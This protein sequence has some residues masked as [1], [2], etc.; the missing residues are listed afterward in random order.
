MERINHAAVARESP[1]R[2]VFDRLRTTGRFAVL[3]VILAIPGHDPSCHQHSHSCVTTT[4]ETTTNDAPWLDPNSVETGETVQ[5]IGRGIRITREGEPDMY[6]LIER[7]N[8]V[9]ELS[10]NGNTYRIRD[11]MNVNVGAAI[12]SATLRDGIMTIVTT[13]H[14]NAKVRWSEV[15]RIASTLDGRTNVDQT[16]S[17]IFDPQGTAL[18]GAINLRRW[19]KGHT[20]G[21]EETYDLAFDRVDTSTEELAMGK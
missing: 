11:T 9:V 19:Y 15:E 4:K 13:E 21:D 2:T 1:S 3:G 6:V 8:G 10:V 18:C 7:R 16:V 20:P 17:T 14:G 5:L 12:A